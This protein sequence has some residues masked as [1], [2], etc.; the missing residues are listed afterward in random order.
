VKKIS[1][2]AGEYQHIKK[3]YYCACVCNHAENEQGSAII[4]ALM[5]LVIMTVIGLM[6][7]ENVVTE[8]FIIRNE[9]IYRQNVSMVE[10]ALMEGF[11]WFM[12]RQPDDPN[13]VDV[14]NSA[15]SWVNSKDDTW[16]ANTWYTADVGFRILS[17]SNSLDVNTSQTLA[18]R[19]ETSAGNLRASFIGWDL[20]P[21]P[22]GGSE[23]LAV[24]ANIPVWRRGRI[25]AEYASRNAG[26]GDNGYGM[27]R[28][29]T[30]LKRRIV[31]N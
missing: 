24:G 1:S 23:S 16:A 21:L 2:H 14:N 3:T 4:I 19:G 6:A 8:N 17:G 15:L 31:I 25:V 30:G 11:Q 26:G 28:M 22:D 29:E 20:V 13:I 7:S 9:A 18:D 5:L 10:A 12:Q 27:L